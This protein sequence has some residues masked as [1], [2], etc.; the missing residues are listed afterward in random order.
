MKHKGLWGFLFV[1]V[2]GTALHFLYEWSGENTLAALVSGVNESVWEHMKLLF[3]PVFL[4]LLLTRANWAVG[5]ASLL[6]GLLFIPA[7]YYTYTGAL[8]FRVAAVDIALFYLAAALVFR[9]QRRLE[10]KW[11]SRRQQT[12]GLMV[13][14]VLALAFLVWTF[15]PP[16]LPLWQ[17]PVSGTFGLLG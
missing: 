1:S 8:G 7:A 6:A 3:V 11:E 12:A 13:L 16:R 5:A 2:L 14:T 17:D 9:L 15:Y 4:W 10:G